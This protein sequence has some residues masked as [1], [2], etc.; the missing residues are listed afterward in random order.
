[1][2][3]GVSFTLI[4]TKLAREDARVQLGVNKLV[5]RFRLPADQ[6]GCG[7]TDVRAIQVR[8]DTPPQASEI[9]VFAETS[10]SAGGA[11]LLAQREGVQDFSV[12]FGVLKISLGVSTQHGF[13]HSNIHDEKGSV[14]LDSATSYFSYGSPTVPWEDFG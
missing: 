8:S 2:H 11:H 10:I 9:S 14:A 12:I 5:G 6:S 3:A 1:M 13:D 4:C 7:G